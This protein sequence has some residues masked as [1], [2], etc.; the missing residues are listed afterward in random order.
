MA[1]IK[2]SIAASIVASMPVKIMSKRA[3]VLKESKAEIDKMVVCS[4]GM[5][6]SLGDAHIRGCSL[7]D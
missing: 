7:A 4:G 1:E 3:H 2:Y 6:Q 5:R